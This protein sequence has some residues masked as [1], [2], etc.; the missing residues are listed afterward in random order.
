MR[1]TL[2]EPRYLKDSISIIS[3]LV[4]EGRFKVT[5][6]GIELVA[7]DPANVAMV[8]YKLL[9]SCF[10]EYDVDEETEISI[11]FNNLKQILK[12][13]SP[14]DVLTL[15]I[16][17]DNKLQI[18]LKDRSVRTFSIPIIDVEEKEQKIPNLEFNTTIRTHASTL[19]SAIEDADIV[20]ESVTF[21]AEPKKF[22]IQAEG[23]LNKAKIEIKESEDT[24]VDCKEKSKSKYSIEYLKKM[25]GGSK[26]SDNVSIQFSKDYPL[27]LEYKAVNRVQ[28]VFILAPRVEND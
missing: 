9:S 13:A 10:T 4:N 11:N 16:T 15:E 21:F 2:A 19:N 27:R 22:V 28:L 8:I 3:E 5:R 17:E 14:S 25:I 6:D 26:L 20:A 12:R 7:M 24:K 1:L 23:D 18:Q